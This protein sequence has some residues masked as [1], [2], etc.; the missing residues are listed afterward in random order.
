MALENYDAYYD[1]C[2]DHSVVDYRR[3]N[4]WPARPLTLRVT[5]LPFDEAVLVWHIAT[6]IC[7]YCT[8]VS[9][10]A[11]D[12]D[13]RAADGKIQLHDVLAPVPAGHA[14]GRH[15]GTQRGRKKVPDP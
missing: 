5:E 1:L 11:E 12:A 10:A 8:D 15:G 13:E 2:K 4:D 6:A 14:D 9:T 7:L 3:F